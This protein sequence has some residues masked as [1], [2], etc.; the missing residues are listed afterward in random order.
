MELTLGTIE[1][2]REIITDNIRYV[3]GYMALMVFRFD[4]FEN[5]RP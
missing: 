1:G 2:S 4:V 3:E 5:L